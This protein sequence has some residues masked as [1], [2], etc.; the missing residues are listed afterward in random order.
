MNYIY[1]CLILIMGMI[2]V[3]RKFDFLSFGA[4]TFV[5][6]TINCAFGE[7]WITGGRTGYYYN[8][9]ISKVTYAYIFLQLACILFYLYKEK[10]GVEFVLGPLNNRRILK[11]GLTNENGVGEKVSLEPFWTTLLWAS[12]FMI[13]YT[14]I[15][16]IGVTNFFSYSRK[17]EFAENVSSLYSFGIWGSVISFLHAVQYSN[18]KKEWISFAMVLITLILGSRAY[19]V[20][21][22]IGAI[23]IKYGEVKNTIRT[24]FKTI[25]GGV[26]LVI[27]LMFFKEIYQDLR[28]LNFSAVKSG[29]LESSITMSLN[30]IAEFRTVFSLYDYVVTSGFKLPILDSLARVL[31]IIPFLNKIIPTS[32]PLRMS[33]IM[34]L[35]LNSSY[36]VGGNF[37][38]ET[39]AMGGGVFLCFVTF[40]WLHYL[41]KANRSIYN[42]CDTSAFP[43]TVASYCAFYIHRLDWVQV[44]GCIKSVLVI[45]LVYCFWKDINVH[46]G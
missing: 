37:W 30:D 17:S 45:Y 26:L 5:F 44:F 31:S 11:S 9:R 36:G 4:L 3:S 27:F 39:I 19:F 25:V 12:V 40:V 46:R 2:I 1:I 33:R 22:I 43:I 15:F 32:E 10:K 38:A 35:S 28:A 16:N 7:T 41:K 21:I 13:M 20:T 42:K 34:K 6:Y 24:N 14:I 23:V 29:L 18:K 8:S